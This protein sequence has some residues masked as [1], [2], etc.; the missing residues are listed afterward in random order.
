[1]WI[2]SKISR[3]TARQRNEGSTRSESEESAGLVFKIQLNDFLL[4]NAC[5]WFV[6]N[7]NPS[8]SFSNIV[9]SLGQFLTRILYSK[10]K[11]DLLISTTRSIFCQVVAY[12]RLK[13]NENFKILALK[14]VAVAHEKCSLTRG[15]KY[16]NLTWKPLVFWKSTRRGE[17][18]AYERWSQPVVRLYPAACGRGLTS[19]RLISLVLLRFWLSRSHSF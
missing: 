12:G 14:V 18:A 9:L 8:K 17:V 10:S 11:Q 1:M 13:T 5:L 7:D 4:L 16:S 19:E 3:I 2:L 6:F 15:S